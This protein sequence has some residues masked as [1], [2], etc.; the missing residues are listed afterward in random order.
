MKTRTTNTNKSTKALENAY[1]KNIH[2]AKILNKEQEKILALHI[3]KG[4]LFCKQ[5]MI[6]SNLRL[7][8]KIAK[9]YIHRGL[10][11][12]DLIEEGNIGLIK[13]VEKFDPNL[14]FRFSTYAS[15]WIKQAIEAAIM[16]QSR[17]VRLPVHILKKIS[18]CVKVNEQLE[19]SLGHQPS[20]QEIADNVHLPTEQVSEL[21]I[22]AETT[23]SIDAFSINYIN[24]NEHS[25]T[26]SASIEPIINNDPI[27]TIQQE[28][29]HDFL[30]DC[31]QQLP[32][33]YQE[34]ITK[35][36]GLFNYKAASLETI[37]KTMGVEQKYIRKIHNKALAKIK[38]YSK[39]HKLDGSS[40]SIN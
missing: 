30:I 21:L 13:A 18:K 19:Y 37:S 34:V 14:G 24:Y 31:L 11:L 25:I 35:R 12:D 38:Q 39:D 36:Y 23:I 3:K 9:S 2:L 26:E 20:L 1:F 10:L 16:N 32:A 4:N 28:N 8:V 15:W 5:Q 27:D 33:N 7:V 40:L 29:V 17:I 22:L 6:V